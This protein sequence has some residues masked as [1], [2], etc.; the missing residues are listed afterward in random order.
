MDRE[1]VRIMP[2]GHWDWSMPTPFSQGWK[3]GDFVF[4][5]GQ[6][7]ADAQGRVIGEGDIEVQTRNVFEAITTVL[8]EAG[9]TWKDVVKLNTYYVFEGEGD[10]ITEFWERMSRI[11][12]EYLVDPGPAA[13][14]VRVAG[15]AYPGLL[16][17]AEAIAVVPPRAA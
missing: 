3:V 5:G 15:L 9:C 7:S 8:R 14:A 12:F 2:A 10:E 1:R 11:R 17:E 6:I 4:V 13:T 16:I